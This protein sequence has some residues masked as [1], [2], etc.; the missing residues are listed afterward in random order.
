[1][2]E[3]H[4]WRNQLTPPLLAP[5]MEESLRNAIMDQHNIGW[6]TFFEGMFST[7][8]IDYQQDYFTSIKSNKEISSWTT[9][10]IKPGWHLIHEIWGKQTL[11]L[12]GRQNKRIERCVIT[13]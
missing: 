9:K 1:M 10:L 3:L 11:K 5:Y 7:Q 6:K 4:V 12:H 13:Q 8:I 2:K